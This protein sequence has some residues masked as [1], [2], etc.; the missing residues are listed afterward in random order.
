MKLKISQNLKFWN[1]R[2]QFNL[3][4]NQVSSIGNYKI[5]KQ[6][7]L[8]IIFLFVVQM[9]VFVLIPLNYFQRLLLSDP[10]LFLHLSQQQNWIFLFF[11]IES[12]VFHLQMYR[13]ANS[14]LQLVQKVMCS[15]DDLINEF[16]VLPAVPYKGRLKMS[17]NIVRDYTQ[18]YLYGIWYFVTF[19]SMI[20]SKVVC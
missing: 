15:N 17:L 8:L 9:L 13:P 12:I 19:E 4:L 16:F 3:Y 5:F 1:L 7:S 11:S 18:K 20:E 14:A 6:L 2:H 10:C